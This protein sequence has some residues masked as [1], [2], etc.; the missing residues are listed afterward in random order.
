MTYD[1][2]QLL[3][4]NRAQW[5]RFTRLTIFCTVAVAI[6]LILMAVFLV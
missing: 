3:E 4:Q 6:T 5:H 2:D 1:P